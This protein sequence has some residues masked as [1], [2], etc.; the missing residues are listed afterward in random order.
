MEGL[1]VIYSVFAIFLGR[2]DL[3]F[4]FN[5]SLSGPPKRFFNERD[6]EHYNINYVG[7]TYCP[8]TFFPAYAKTSKMISSN[9]YGRHINLE[10]RLKGGTKK[11]K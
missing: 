10:R 5:F 3:Q 9:R 7:R 6:R 11:W 4:L 2:S 1:S 8:K